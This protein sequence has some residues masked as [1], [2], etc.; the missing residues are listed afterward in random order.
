MTQND[1]S[2]AG[3]QLVGDERTQ[4]GVVYKAGEDKTED[5]VQIEDHPPKYLV[6]GLSDSPPIHITIICGLQVLESDW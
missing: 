6:Y 5:N 4:E 3:S 1:I 2:G